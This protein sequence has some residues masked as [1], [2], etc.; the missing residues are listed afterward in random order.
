MWL[1]ACR[2][3]NSESTESSSK[4]QRAEQGRLAAV[5]EAGQ[6]RSSLQASLAQA[7]Q[8]AATAEAAISSSQQEKQQLQQQLQ[9]V[10]AQARTAAARSQQEQQQLRQQLQQAEA[11]GTG[12][13]ANQTT[14]AQPGESFTH[15]PTSGISHATLTRPTNA[16]SLRLVGTACVHVRCCQNC[17]L[18]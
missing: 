2:Q 5:A 3:L 4:Y 6:V 10:E 9:E 7:E 13:T 12:A 11:Q 16:A 14:T 8:R 1:C 17:M 18:M 15:C